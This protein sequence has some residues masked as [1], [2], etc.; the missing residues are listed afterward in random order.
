M[1]IVTLTLEKMV[2]LLMSTL[3]LVKP[4]LEIIQVVLTLY[5][6]EMDYSKLATMMI[7]QVI[8]AILAITMMMMTLATLAI[9]MMMM[10]L[11][12]LAI[13]AILAIMMMMMI[14]VMHP[15]LHYPHLQ[16]LLV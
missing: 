2:F 16:Q 11:A 6:K 15:R 1:G 13:L 7:T 3:V 8:L 14:A 10:T 12:T 4:M 9:M 5:L